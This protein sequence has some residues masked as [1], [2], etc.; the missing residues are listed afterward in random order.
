MM[1]PEDADAV[2]LVRRSRNV[3]R[4]RPARLL[5][6]RNGELRVTSCS[7]STL[8]VE[9]AAC[10]HADRDVV[11]YC[12]GGHDPIAGATTGAIDG[13]ACR[14]G[15][16][17]VSGVANGSR[18]V[19]ARVDLNHRTGVERVIPVDRNRGG[20]TVRD[21]PPGPAG[22][23]DVAEVEEDWPGSNLCPSRG[24]RRNVRNRCVFSVIG[25]EDE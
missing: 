24:R 4:R 2:R 13:Q 21:L 15:V 7:R 8:P 14:V 10:G 20:L 16:A 1:K 17:E 3:E 19:V 9:H 6:M 22:Q 25:P 18:R 11:V 5:L 12:N 23:A